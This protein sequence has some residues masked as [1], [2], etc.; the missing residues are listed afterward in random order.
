MFPLSLFLSGASV[1]LHHP[2]RGYGTVKAGGSPWGQ[3]AV[4][5]SHGTVWLLQQTPV[6]REPGQQLMG[7]QQHSPAEAL[8]KRT[9][10][11]LF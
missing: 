10:T 8:V 7:L 2:W 4:T 11:E 6:P 1:Y 5:H 3:S 9:G